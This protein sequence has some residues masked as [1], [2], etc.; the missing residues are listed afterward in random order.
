EG[1][2]N[3]RTSNPRSRQPLTSRTATTGRTYA[4]RRTDPI[5][6]AADPC[7][8]TDRRARAAGRSAS[9][10]ARLR[11]PPPEP[12]IPLLRQRPHHRPHIPPNAPATP[13]SPYGP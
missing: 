8:P 9:P 13:P 4:A 10:T 12:S 1:I 5:V 11:G 3:R 7:D 6:A 2:R